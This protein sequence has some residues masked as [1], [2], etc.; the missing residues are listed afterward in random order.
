NTRHYFAVYQE[1][2]AITCEEIR[3]HGI[4]AFTGNNFVHCVHDCFQALELLNLVYDRGL[5][6]INTGI[7]VGN[8][9]PERTPKGQARRLANRNCQQDT[10]EYAE[11]KC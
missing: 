6:Y 9:R 5:A 4:F 7:S 2:K 11:Y 1:Q 8:C 10:C 3:K